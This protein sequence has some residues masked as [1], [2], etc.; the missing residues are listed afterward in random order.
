[1]SALELVARTISSAV[2]HVAPPSLLMQALS[3]LVSF[4][5]GS[6]ALRRV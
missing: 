2:F 5:A 3:S 6:H 4:F 1:M